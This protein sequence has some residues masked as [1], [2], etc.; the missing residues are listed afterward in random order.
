MGII[1]SVFSFYLFSSSNNKNEKIKND[2]IYENIRGSVRPKT[3]KDNSSDQVSGNM[4]ENETSDILELML[5][6]MK[7]IQEY[8]GLSKTQAKNSLFLAIIMYVLGTIL[9]GISVVTAV[10]NTNNLTT[11]IVPAVRGAIVELIA[12]TSLIVYRN[13]QKQLNHYYSHLHDNGRFLSTVNIVNKLNPSKR[14]EMYIEIIRSQINHSNY[15][16]AE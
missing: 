5:A 14:D 11:T 15:K 10:T 7:A 13:S 1:P 9:L 2:E 8:Y 12:S 6:N 3:R 16:S 4:N